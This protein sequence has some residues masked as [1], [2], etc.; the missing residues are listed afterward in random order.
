[1][2]TKNKKA[3][4]TIIAVTVAVSILVAFSA[5]ASAADIYVND[6]ESIQAAITGASDYDTI[7]VATGTY[8]GFDVNKQ[9]TLLGANHDVDPAGS[10]D[11]SGE[12]AIVGQVTVTADA[13]TINGF[14]LTSSY[15]AAGNPQA[16]DITIS[17]NILDNV[18][19]P[20]GAIHLH[21]GI[22]QCDGAYVGYNTIINAQGD[23]IW[24]VG[25]D[26]V[27]I[28]YNHI[29]DNT[30][31]RA[32]EA[33]NHVGTG[34]VIHGN[35][36]TNSGGKGI[37]YWAEDGGVITDN[38]ITNSNFE[39]IYTDAQAT[40]SGNQISGGNM[41]GILVVGGAADST[42]SGNTISNTNWEG[43]QSDVPVTITN[44]D[45]SGGYNGIQL[46]N[47]A[48]GSV[49]DGNTI[50]SPSWIG[51][52]SFVPVDITNNNINGGWS[53]LEILSGAGGSTVNDN[54]V[55]GTTAEALRVFAQA[56]ITNN[57]FSGGYSGIGI[58]ADGTVIDGNNIH[59]N[60]YWGLYIQPSVTDV[61]VTN[62]QLANN[63]YCGVIV[64]GDGDGSGIH[65]NCNEITG[66][67]FY[68]VES[69]RTS[70]VDAEN[71][72]WGDASGPTHA[73]NPSG[74]G[75]AVSDNVDYDPWAGKITGPIDPVEVG[76]PIDVTGHFI[77]SSIVVATFC[78]GDGSISYLDISPGDTSVTCSHTYTEAGVYTVTLKVSDGTAHVDLGPGFMDRN[79]EI[80][81]YVVVYDPDGGF[82]TGGGW[83]YSP[84][85]ASAQ[86]PD[87]EGK[88]TFGFVSKYKKGQTTPTGNTEFQFKAGDLNFHSD[89]YDWLVIAGSKAKYKGT[90]TINGEGSYK[91]MLSAIDGD[92]N[93]GDGIDKFR[94]KIWEEDTNGDETIIYDNGE[95]TGD[96]ETLTELSGGQ[97]V[98]HKTK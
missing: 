15:I 33:L 86:Y 96:G 44:N 79:S 50:S 20:W 6:G 90:G 32:I 11:R 63:P 14:K 10:S 5:T 85:G 97:I 16:H 2:K 53:G 13:A 71:N 45:I 29:L 7:H 41:Y 48:S 27:T 30:G 58:W 62:N 12:S 55:S 19:A 1:M 73:S 93:N 82:V 4:S 76:T 39:A 80:F 81:L 52:K 37:N 95:D 57:D 35:T 24:T 49:I 92:L 69:K 54:T 21:G 18:E 23:G 94:I 34:I 77:G 83:I 87:A 98:I 56:T 91:F 25:N 61:V 42:V 28:E 88:A 47:A 40:I 78:W 59:G 46:S 60:T 68:G 38:V 3:I 31:D 70:D 43:I 26:G 67:G 22:N 66:N 65:I 84:A 51:I 75:D 74:I 17:Y 64:Q 8:T 89:S 72:W 36:I 9:V